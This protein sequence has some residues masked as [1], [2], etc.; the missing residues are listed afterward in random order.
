MGPIPH[1]LTVDGG[2]VVRVDWL[3][4]IP[5]HTV[6]VTTVGGREPIALLVVS[7][8]TPTETAWAALNIAAAN[9]GI[10]QTADVLIAEELQGP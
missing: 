2:R 6:S 8:D 9:P 1:R 4:T 5:R 7:P 3:T 10:P